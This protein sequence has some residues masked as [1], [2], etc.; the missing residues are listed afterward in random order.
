MITPH[1]DENHDIHGFISGWI[2]K[3]AERVDKLYGIT[4]HHNTKTPL[5]GNVLVYGVNHLGEKWDRASKAVRLIR[6]LGRKIYFHST[7]LRVIP[8]VDVV[9]CHMYPEFTIRVAPYAKLFRK[10][11]VTWFTHGHVSRR[12]RIAHF[13]SDK[14][15]TASKESLRIK[16]NKIIIIGHGIDTDRFKPV[17][18]QNNKIDKKT[19]LSVGRISPRKN[20]ETLIK[21]ADILV[22][23]KNIKYLE[24]VIVGGVPMAS[25]EEYYER[26][27]KLVKELELEGYVKFVG[28]VPYSDILGYY[29]K[30]DLF[31]STSQTGSVDKNVLEAMA[32]EKTVI[33]CNETFE[34]VF[35]DYS[36]ILMFK[37]EA[38]YDLTQKI[39]FI[40]EMD[41]DRHDKLCF[42]MREIV[43]RE[44]NVNGLMDKLI[45]V[46]EDSRR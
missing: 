25:Q 15:V 13:L 9:F 42:A 39:I 30:C 38:P 45:K 28:S 6:L 8:K 3:L 19:I 20:Y 40:L 23:E 12:L 44:H 16:S 14:M 18:N 4:P 43:K 22:N 32:C 29:Q 31:V 17:V 21:A 2:R 27:K 41:E 24:F 26:L 35:G 11:I 1:I 7:I 46:F 5:P 34:D 37:K 36:K 10:P 33:V